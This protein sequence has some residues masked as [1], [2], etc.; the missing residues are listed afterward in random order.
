MKTDLRYLERLSARG[1]SPK[2]HPSDQTLAEFLDGRLDESARKELLEHL[3]NCE[4]CS[5]IIAEV[6]PAGRARRAA[7]VFP[8]SKKLGSVL[9]LAA[10]LLLAVWFSLPSQAPKVGKINLAEE[11]AHGRYMAPSTL[12][13]I[14]SKMIDG[15]RLL[16]TL[17]AQTDMRNSPNYQKG[18]AA[19]RDGDYQT[20]RR[21]YKEALIALRHEPDTLKRLAQKIVINYRLLKLGKQESRETEASIKAYQKLLR[22]EIA[23]YFYYQERAK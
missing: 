2:R 1:D 22:H 10:S 15:D 13:N 19:E 4:R 7:K 21:Y 8:F 14:P 12:K 11:L 23:L 9:A 3:A 20:A 6:P 5:Q 17:I 16:K 18:V